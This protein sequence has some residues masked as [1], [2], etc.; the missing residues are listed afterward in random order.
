MNKLSL[1]ER[2]KIVRCLVEGNSLRSTVRI[3]DIHRTTIQNLLVDLGAACSDYQDKAFRNLK[4]GKI[5]CDEIWAF[6]GA[7]E[8]NATPTQK[9]A[10]PACQASGE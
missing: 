7:K 1:D 9:A 10:C 2:V 4:L 5:Q 8:K 6:C 3:T